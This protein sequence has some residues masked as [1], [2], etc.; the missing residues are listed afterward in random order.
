[1][2]R[3]YFRMIK[4]TQIFAICLV[5]QLFLACTNAGTQTTGVPAPQAAGAFDK[6]VDNYFDF[7]FQ[8]NPTAATQTGFHQYD[9]KLEDYS[10]SGIDSEVA[11]LLKFRDQFVGIHG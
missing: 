1:M 3:S 5:I 2:R 10:R 9:A 4:R 7:Y 11:G 8:T 6:L